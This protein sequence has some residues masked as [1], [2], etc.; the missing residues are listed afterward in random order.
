MRL[1]SL[2]ATPQRFV[3]AVFCCW[4]DYVISRRTWP[5][6][7]HRVSRPTSMIWS[8][9]DVSGDT[10]YLAGTENGKPVNDLRIYVV[11]MN[12]SDSIA[13]YGKL[14]LRISCESTQITSITYSF[15]YA[16]QKLQVTSAFNGDSGKVS[17]PIASSPQGAVVNVELVQCNVK[18]ERS[19]M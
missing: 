14:P 19:I 18:V 17:I 5:Q 16:L 10:Y 4:C 3:G 6:W 15:D 8:W 2:P 7:I 13:L 11:N 1:F 12:N 9:F